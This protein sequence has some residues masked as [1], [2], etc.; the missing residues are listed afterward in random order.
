MQS[1]ILS[2][3][4]LFMVKCLKS[5]ICS[6]HSTHI[7]NLWDTKLCRTCSWNQPFLLAWYLRESWSIVDKLAVITCSYNFLA[8]RMETGEGVWEDEGDDDDPSA[9]LVSTHTAGDAL[10][11]VRPPL[12]TCAT[13]STSS[14]A[15]NRHSS[16][17]LG[18]LSPLAP[19]IIIAVEKT[20]RASSRLP[21][22]HSRW[23]YSRQSTSDERLSGSL[24]SCFATCL[25][26]LPWERRRFLLP[27]LRQRK[28]YR[29]AN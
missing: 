12:G 15:H 10:T 11:S 16:Q 14:W 18:L 8:F 23:P 2:N 21:S 25:L 5:Y 17:R 13:S 1:W 6:F 3:W 4:F 22:S 19:P 29:E 27:L 28:T 7:I 9:N 26:L 24:S 20:L